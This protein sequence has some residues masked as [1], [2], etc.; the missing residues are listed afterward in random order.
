MLKNNFAKLIFALALPQL[1]GVV[2][3]WITLPAIPTWYATLVKP[4][5]NP[6]NFVFGPVWTGLY[7]LMGVAFY[8]V[9]TTKAKASDLRFA[10]FTFALQL[11]LNLFWSVAFFGLQDPLLSFLVICSLFVAIVVNIFTFAK[12]SKFAGALLL[13]YLAWVS[14]AGYLNYAIWMLN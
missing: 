14:F 3:S 7:L 6:P 12:I 11:A 5:L 4:A 9:W 1:I 10:I 2:G 8:L 13:P